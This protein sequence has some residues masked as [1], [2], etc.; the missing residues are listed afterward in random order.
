[1]HRLV[2]LQLLAILL[3]LFS[4]VTEKQRAKICATCQH[5]DSLVIT[6]HDTIVYRDTT[7]FLS[8]TGDTITI[9]SPCDSTKLR[10]FDVIK[11][12]NGI[13][14]ELKSNGKVI[15]CLC[16]DDSLL[17]VIKGIRADHFAEIDSTKSETRLLNCDKEHH[18]G[19]DTFCNWFTIITLSI[20]IGA[21][22]VFAF[23]FF[24]K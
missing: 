16:K 15:E 7:L 11:K 17:L 13:V 18:T 23:K 21:T 1:M 22:V 20:C 14:S 2:K 24:K 12:R 8:F 9:P 4:C 6:K 3:G 10:T 5:A 19:W